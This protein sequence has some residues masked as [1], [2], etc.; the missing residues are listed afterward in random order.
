MQHVG[1]RALVRVGF[2][3]GGPDGDDSQLV[4]DIQ[5]VLIETQTLQT[6]QITV[7]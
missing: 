3:G 4:V 7:T 2:L 6:T 5:Y 1:K